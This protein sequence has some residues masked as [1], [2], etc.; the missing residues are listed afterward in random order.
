VSLVSLLSLLPPLVLLSLSLPLPPPP[1]PPDLRPDFRLAA[2]SAAGAGGGA[3]AAPSLLF[4]PRA[5]LEGL[6]PSDVVTSSNRFFSSLSCQIGIFQTKFLHPT[7]FLD[8]PELQ[9]PGTR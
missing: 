6:P 1:P 5:G 2:V 3:A 7:S 8:L 9:I 4:R